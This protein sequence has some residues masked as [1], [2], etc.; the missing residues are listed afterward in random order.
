VYIDPND[1]EYHQLP[2]PYCYKKGWNPHYRYYTNAVFKIKALVGVSFRRA[3]KF[4]PFSW[5]VGSTPKR[6][7]KNIE[8]K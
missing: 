4:Q 2:I 6:Q 1:M 5:R 8:M 3:L 7:S